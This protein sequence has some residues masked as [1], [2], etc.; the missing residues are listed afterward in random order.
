[1]YLSYFKCYLKVVSRCTRIPLT[2]LGQEEKEKLVHLAEKLHERVIGQDEAVNLVA[3]AVLR[4][5]VGFGR[6]SRPIGSFLFL[7]PLGVGKTELAKA[8]A[9][10]IFDNEKALIR[11]D[12]SEYA[13]SGSVSR[14][15]GGPRRFDSPT[16]PGFRESQEVPIQRCPF[17]PGW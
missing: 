3:Q 15:I 1:M 11:F 10:R 2:T 13:E 6:S 16:L 17:R 14:L 5:R 9:E 8:L 4:S 7:G 12:M